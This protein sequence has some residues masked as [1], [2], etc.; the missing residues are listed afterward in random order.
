M[1]DTAQE[2]GFVVRLCEEAVG[3]ALQPLQD[4]MRIGK[5][6]KKH[7]GNSFRFFRLFQSGAEGEAV[8]LWH[9]DI[10]E[11]QKNLTSPD[12]F[13]R[14]FPV[15]RRCHPVPVALENVPQLLSLGYAVLHN[16]DSALV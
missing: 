1:V 14:L 16:Q 15:S 6:S 3:A 8:D 7:N 10:A 13:K 4:V 11:N 12:C 9:D 2:V 5:G